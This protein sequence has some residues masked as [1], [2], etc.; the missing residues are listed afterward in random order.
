M[1]GVTLAVEDAAA[2]FA[3][4]LLDPRI[5]ILLTGDRSQAEEASRALA[6]QLPPDA[7]RRFGPADDL[8]PGPPD[9]AVVLLSPLV[10]DDPARVARGRRAWGIAAVAPSPGHA[11]SAIAERCALAVAFDP[12]QGPAA[13]ESPAP[14]ERAAAA[15]AAAA[16]RA[17]PAAA[18]DLEAR[19]AVEA[20]VR[21]GL[22]SHELE[23]RAALAAR[24]AMRLGLEPMP[25]LERWVFAPRARQ[26]PSV[27]PP[28]A[29]AESAGE[30]P[31][32][33]SNDGA[34]DGAT[35]VEPPGAWPG[36]PPVT[37]TLRGRVRRPLP[38]RRGPRGPHPARG[39]PGRTFPWRY[40]ERA[41]V[42][43]TV[44]YA[45]PRAALR[46]WRPGNVLRLMPGDLRARRRHTKTGSLLIIV[47]DASGSM[48]QGAIRQAKGLALRVL[49]R[50]YV[51]RTSVAIVAARGREAYLA[52]APT[53]AIARARGALREL[54]SGGGTPLASAYAAALRLA[55]RYEP[56]AVRALVLS[57]GRANVPLTPG[58]DPQDEASRMLAVLS[59]AA[60]VE[61]VDR[62]A[63]SRKR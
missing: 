19:T 53:R 37:A 21:F 63:L 60:Q 10:F 6:R 49:D 27:P 1:H 45:L 50:A 13:L 34:A 4:F 23:Y 40:G 47:V 8:W 11:P 44:A 31:G 26:A 20:A 15:A 56:A 54:P 43:A 51:D 24:A 22:E 17:A 48:A 42:P 9:D 2:P 18:P 35:S 12:T 41:D 36:D 29:D 33:P 14:W 55:R 5:G 62:R 61:V 25:F 3:A 59:R 16:A 57:D 28:P 30:E 39:A 46:G 58:G 38:G 52:L 32:G 7:V